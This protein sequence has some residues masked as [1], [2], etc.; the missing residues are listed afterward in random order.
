MH[1]ISAQKRTILGKKTSEL[2]SRGVLPAVVYGKGGNSLPLSL[3]TSDF[4]KAWRKS[5]ESTILNLALDDSATK[6]VLI[7]EVSVDS[8]TGTPIHV[9]FFEVSADKPIKAHVPVSFVG[10]SPAVK[11]DG[12]V[13]VKVMYEIEI[14]ALPKD[15]PHEIQIDLSGL[16]QFS[17]HILLKDILLPKGV[18]L[19]GEAG[20]LVVKVIAPRSDAEIA[21]TEE[22]AVV[23][24]E[25]IE[26]VKKGKKEEEVVPEESGE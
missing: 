19:H 12:G 26:V 17:D 9:D 13:L 18:T 7:H 3:N 10:E 21:A 6:N 14:E 23:D 4:I 20:A 2:R 1:T 11:S 5:G 22:T 15:L 24:L 16:K 25:A 8:L